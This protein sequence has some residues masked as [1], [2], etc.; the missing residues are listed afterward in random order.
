MCKHT[1]KT[2]KFNDVAPC[3]LVPLKGSGVLKD[4]DRDADRCQNLR[5]HP[6]RYMKGKHLAMAKSDFN[7]IIE[8][9]RLGRKRKE[10]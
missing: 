4:R 5:P 3:N 7:E 2:T 8:R 10:V 6:Y 1:V 9:G